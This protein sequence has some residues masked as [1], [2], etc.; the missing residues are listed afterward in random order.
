MVERAIMIA[1]LMI[2]ICAT[3][4]IAQG[5]PKTKGTG[6][7]AEALFDQSLTPIESR[8]CRNAYNRCD[9]AWR[10]TCCP[11]LTCSGSRPAYCM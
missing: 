1:V 3:A 2:T 6:M 11:G 9:G 4:N 5:A 7:E 8:N 10:N